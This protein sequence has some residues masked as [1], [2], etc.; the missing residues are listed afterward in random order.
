MPEPER[1][2]DEF[3]SV[4]AESRKTHCAGSVR[5]VNGALAADFNDFAKDN[6]PF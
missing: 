5:R 6:F 2:L 3:V 4:Q 1:L